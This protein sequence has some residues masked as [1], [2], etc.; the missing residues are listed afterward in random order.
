MPQIQFPDFMAVTF[1]LVTYLLGEAINAKVPPLRRFNI[2]D[3]VTGGLIVA[4]GLLLLYRLE[5]AAVGFDTVAR[6]LLLLIFFTAIGLN[7]RI[8]DLLR[9]GRPLA[10]L[11]AI[12]AGLLLL[13][14]L[15]GGLGP[16]IAGLPLAMGVVLGSTS[17]LIAFRM[18]GEDYQAAVLTAGYA[19]FVLG[20]T[21]T[22][23][24]TMTAITKRHG[25]C[26]T[27]FIV[28]RLRRLRR[29]L[30][31]PGDPGLPRPVDEVR[32]VAARR[33]TRPAP[34]R[35]PPPTAPRR[36]PG[37]AGQRPA[38]GEAAC[39]RPS[40]RR[41]ASGVTGAG[42]PLP[43]ARPRARWLHRQDPSTGVAEHGKWSVKPAT[44]DPSTATRWRKLH[45]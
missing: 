1:G 17:L 20:A 28:L 3:P 29:H 19:S 44:A 36:D 22:A 41:H 25:P 30:R 23:I 16:W 32:G 10:V 40:C 45:A 15:V 38:R 12:T 18:L 13:Q 14:N 27:A 4:F 35:E 7:A 26:Q 21:P 37:H 39:G 9:G 11:V 6:D 8:G 5:I 34:F 42:R 33:I 43:G 24:A 31:R 2:P